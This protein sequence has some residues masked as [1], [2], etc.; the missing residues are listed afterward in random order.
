MC[1][2]DWTKQGQCAPQR[3][4]NLLQMRSC[5]TILRLN[6]QW[7]T[8][9]IKWIANVCVYESSI[10]NNNVANF[11]SSSG[12]VAQLAIYCLLHYNQLCGLLLLLQKPKW[13]INW[14]TSSF[15]WENCY[16]IYINQFLHLKAISRRL[17]PLSTIKMSEIKQ[18][19]SIGQ[20]WLY[21]LVVSHSRAKNGHF[22]S[23]ITPKSSHESQLTTSFSF[24]FYN[25]Q[26]I[27]HYY[28]LRAA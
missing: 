21:K 19:C 22:T 7:S 25:N 16:Q 15:L 27:W 20:L 11:I 8:N 12:V 6:N 18:C 10:D 9:N 13:S 17:H 3:D 14:S 26:P 2:F 24:H 28:I 1:S 4:S 23:T 5:W